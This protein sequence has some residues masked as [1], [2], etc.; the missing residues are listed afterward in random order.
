ML[1]EKTTFLEKGNWPEDL[2]CWW[3]EATKAIDEFA[4]RMGPTI[5]EMSDEEFGLF[6]R[7]YQEL[8]ILLE[9]LL[10]AIQDGVCW[11]N[12]PESQ[13]RRSYLYDRDCDSDDGRM[14]EMEHAC[15]HYRTM[16]YFLR[17]IE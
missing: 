3:R 16:H 6:L 11:K 9:S 1:E 8:T 2:D 13:K 17:H 15:V 14:G 7:Q 4:K 5:R 10:E 12:D